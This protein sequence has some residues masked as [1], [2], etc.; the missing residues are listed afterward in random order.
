[1]MRLWNPLCSAGILAS[2]LLCWPAPSH[3]APPAKPTF[4]KDI[5]PLIN[6]YCGKC[7]SDKKCV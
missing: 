6:R 7:H 4:A 1:M 3:A 5:A 2:F